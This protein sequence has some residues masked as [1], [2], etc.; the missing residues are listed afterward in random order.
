MH[1]HPAIDLDPYSDN[2]LADPSEFFLA[3][4]SAGSVVRVPQ[5]E[6][7]DIVAV[8]RDAT[9]RS[10]LENHG[11]FLNGRGGGILDLQHDEPFREPGVLQ[12]TDQPYHSRVRNVMTSI[13]SPRHLRALRETFQ[14]IADELV[15]AAL[16]KGEFD[17]QVDLAEAFPLR[18]VPDTIMGAPP[19]GRENLLR[20]STFLFESMGPRT[21]RATAVLE[22]IDNLQSA[23]DWVG[24]SS[25]RENVSQDSL[26]VMLWE[27]VD[28][29]ELTAKEAE[30]MVRSLL[31]AGVDTT[32]YALGQ[33]IQQLTTNPAQ[34]E[35]L[36]ERPE[37]G[38]F[39]FE[40][41]LRW[42]SPVRQIW[43]TPAKD[44]DVDGIPIREGQKLMIVLGAAN[45]D[46]GRWGEKADQYDLGRDAGGHLAMG[47]GIHACVGGPIARLEAD[48]LLSTFARRV[49][50]IEPTGDPVPLL[51]NTLRGWTSVPVRVAAA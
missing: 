5:S 39:A 18:A 9:A 22:S 23:I 11:D 16:E 2:V 33:T 13:I 25:D 37:R 30:L 46:P 4:R 24:K 41:G 31:S 38:K 19:E 7:F 36:H 35:L 3:L 1:N 43:R 49:K 50:A 21:P 27:A 42:G 45:Q 51:N 12:E 29:E 34:W 40:E 20:Y 14:V 8:G 47:R 32:I 17:A 28:R 26:G 10:I 6:G 44:L 15:D 48:V